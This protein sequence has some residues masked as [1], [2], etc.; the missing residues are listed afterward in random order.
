M[1]TIDWYPGTDEEWGQTAEAFKDYL[2]D[3][4][5]L[6]TQG[7]DQQS[8]ADANQQ[9]TTQV[10]PKAMTLD[11]AY[12]NVYVHGDNSDLAKQTLEAAIEEFRPKIEYMYY[13]LGGSSKSTAIKL[14]GYSELHL[15]PGGEKD[16]YSRSTRPTYAEIV[17]LAIGSFTLRDII[18]RLMGNTKDGGRRL[19]HG[20]GFRRLYIGWVHKHVTSYPDSV[21][22]VR[23][24]I[25]HK[26]TH[27]IV[28]AETSGM[29]MVVYAVIVSK[30]HEEGPRGPIV[31][32]NLPDW[33]V[34]DE[35]ARD[36]QALRQARPDLF[37][38]DGSLKRV[39]PSGKDSKDAPAGDSE[40]KADSD[41][42]S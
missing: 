38:A 29:K 35:D 22:T 37:N 36:L 4:A 39:K 17:A 18:I 20:M 24:D 10:L 42:K 15:I 5:N 28:P 13:L 34:D 30:N 21:F 26:I 16:P 9:I 23:L 31:T 8:N 14:Q 19:E 6:N 27:Y 1:A 12:R 7:W 33:D 25:N 2:S 40:S 41:D 32:I 3:T 11:T